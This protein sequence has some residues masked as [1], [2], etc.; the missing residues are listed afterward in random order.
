M[1]FKLVLSLLLICR[2]GFADEVSNLK[3][4]IQFTTLNRELQAE[5]F[6]MVEEDQSVVNFQNILD[7]DQKKL[8]EVRTKHNQRL[9]EIISTYGWPGIQ[10]VGLEGASGMWLLVQHQDKDLAFQK[11]CLVLLK[12]AVEKQEAQ[13]REYAYLLDRVRKNE[14]LPQVYGT[15]WELKD[16]KWLLY[17]LETPENLNQR[18]LEAGLNS[19]EEY[20][21]EMK[22]IFHLKDTDISLF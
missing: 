8:N 9:K 13:A 16:R 2:W 1:R 7:Q 12:E 17:S 14:N 20:A 10:L 22:K 15:Q 6:A 4:S 11:Q 21:E 5:I 18:R 19:I 3:Q